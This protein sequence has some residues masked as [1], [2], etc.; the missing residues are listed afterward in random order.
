VR[1]APRKD[2]RIVILVSS[3]MRV[4]VLD[5]KRGCSLIKAQELRLGTHARPDEDPQRQRRLGRSRGAVRGRAGGAGAGQTEGKS[6]ARVGV[7]SQLHRLL[8]K[9][10]RNV[11]AHL[12]ALRKRTAKPLATERQ[13]QQLEQALL[14]ELEP[15]PAVFLP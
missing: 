11:E 13:N 3:G 14:R 10:R 8:K 12:S 5:E 15:L 1:E 4:E 2:F 6:R 7:L 9:R